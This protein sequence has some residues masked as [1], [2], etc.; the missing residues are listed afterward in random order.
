M[1]D[2][3]SALIRAEGDEDFAELYDA[4]VVLVE[5]IRQCE[6]EARLRLPVCFDDLI[7]TVNRCESTIA[8][9]DRRIAAM[10]NDGD[11]TPAEPTG[12]AGIR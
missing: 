1:I 10:A 5:W 7:R 2:P 11:T 8:E 3:F 9:F 12:K 6:V 4:A